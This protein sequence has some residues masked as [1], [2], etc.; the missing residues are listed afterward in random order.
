MTTTRPPG[1]GTLAGLLEIY[2]DAPMDAGDA[3]LLLDGRVCV[4]I[5]QLATN[6]DEQL[7]RNTVSILRKTARNV[8]VA[9]A[10]PQ[11]RLLPSDRKLWW[12]LHQ[13]L[14]SCDVELRPIQALPAA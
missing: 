10:R 3:V 12:E 9:I 1:D 7:L 14:H 4:E 5:E 13:E 8:V 2:A 6:W 11:G